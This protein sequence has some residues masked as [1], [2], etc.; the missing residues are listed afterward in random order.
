MAMPTIKAAPAATNMAA[1][2]PVGLRISE[3]L[4]ATYR[5][6]QDRYADPQLDKLGNDHVA[7]RLQSTVLKACEL[8]PWTPPEIYDWTWCWLHL[9]AYGSE[10]NTKP[11]K[12]FYGGG[13]PRRRRVDWV[14]AYP[15]ISM[16]EELLVEDAERNR[17]RALP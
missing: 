13:A 14:T 2:A 1:A 8:Y 5:Q 10:A 17:H 3:K 16:I 6:L 15:D 9:L 7:E 11:I 4:L 12:L